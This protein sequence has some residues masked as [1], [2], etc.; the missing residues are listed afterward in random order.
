MKWQKKIT[1]MWNGIPFNKNKM[2][3][4]FWSDERW[5]IYLLKWEEKWFIEWWKLRKTKHPKTHKF[6]E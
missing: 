4:D 6:N 2:S 5:N 3:F 1:K